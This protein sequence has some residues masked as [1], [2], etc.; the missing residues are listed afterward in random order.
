VRGFRK[1]RQRDLICLI[2]FALPK[3]P[4]T[5]FIPFESD[6]QRCPEMSR[7]KVLEKAKTEKAEA[8]SD[9]SDM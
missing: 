5:W 4:R 6:V 2:F 3:L 1:D 7:V 9:M 8:A